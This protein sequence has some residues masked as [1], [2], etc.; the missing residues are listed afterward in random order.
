[1]NYKNELII[2]IDDVKELLDVGY[3]FILKINLQNELICIDYSAEVIRFN[4]ITNG[5]IPGSIL[6]L[7]VT[8]ISGG[9]IYAKFEIVG[10]FNDDFAFPIKSFNEYKNTIIGIIKC[11]RKMNEKFFS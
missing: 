6:K 7:F 10:G 5:K 8:K 4:F 2:S 3:E 1:M 9:D 11:W